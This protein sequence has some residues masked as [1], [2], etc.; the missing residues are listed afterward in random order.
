MCFMILDYL[1]DKSRRKMSK[2]KGAQ[3]QSQSQSH[4]KIDNREK[5]FKTIEVLNKFRK[6]HDNVD[7]VTLDVGDFVMINEKSGVEIYIERKDIKDFAASIIDG[8]YHEQH[9]RLLKVRESNEKA[10]ILYIVEKFNVNDDDDLKKCVGSSRITYET[11]M[12]SI[13]KLSLRD[14]ICVIQ[15]TGIEDTIRWLCKI[16]SNLI[17]EQFVPKSDDKKEED[18]IRARVASFKKSNSISDWWLASLSSVYGMSP[19]KAKAIVN[20]YPD[21]HSL[22]KAYNECESQSERESLISKI[23]VNNRAISWNV[24]LRVYTTIYGTSNVVNDVVN[25]VKPQS[26]FSKKFVKA[27]KSSRSF[28]K[29]VSE[30]EE[31]GCLID[32]D[33]E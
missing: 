21:V 18:L 14:D 25:D 16:W 32:S 13:T 8:R 20:K 3:S 22:I 15:T 9:S 10:K 30:I 29:K 2:L 27:K 11:I 31:S 12:S 17:K 33:D 26:K 7:V 24:S 4:F 1:T 19:Q 5:P 23:Q 28:V 6:I